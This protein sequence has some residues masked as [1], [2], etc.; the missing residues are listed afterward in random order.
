VIR[1]LRAQL[2]LWHGGLL[3][4]TLILLASVTYLVLR[5]VLSS[6]ADAALHDYAEVTAR[7]I[8]LAVSQKEY[9]DPRR[10][11]TKEQRAKIDR[12]AVT[13]LMDSVS[14]WGRFVQIDDA[15][16]AEAVD[17]GVARG[18]AAADDQRAARI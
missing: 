15:D 17:R 5:Q 13:Q 8:A 14:S 3:A 18:T 11:L 9:L 10:S 1:S 6:L 16:R 2:A 7:N 12:D 4:L